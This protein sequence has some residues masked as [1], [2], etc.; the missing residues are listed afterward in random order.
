MSESVIRLPPTE[1]ELF[2]DPNLEYWVRTV[3]IKIGERL[4]DDSLQVGRIG[5]LKAYRTFDP[6]KTRRGFKS[7]IFTKIRGEFANLKRKRARAQKRRGDLALSFSPT[8]YPNPEDLLDCVER[9]IQ[10]L[11][12]RETLGLT[13]SQARLIWEGA[14]AGHGSTALAERTGVALPKV[15][16]FLRHV[17]KQIRPTTQTRGQ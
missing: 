1:D 7:W 3:V 4:D 17:R 15:Q 5:L 12:I 10:G 2:Q 13:Q 9:T 11:R 8:T 14:Q 16:R 6:E